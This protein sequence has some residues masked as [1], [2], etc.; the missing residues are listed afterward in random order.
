[1]LVTLGLS[2]VFVTTVGGRVCTV[3]GIGTD[4]ETGGHGQALEG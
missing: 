2:V 4:E 1:M 3:Q